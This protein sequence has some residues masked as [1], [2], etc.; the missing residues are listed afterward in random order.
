MNYDTIVRPIVECADAL[1]ATPAQVALAWVLAQSDCIVV[2][3][4]TQRYSYLQENWQAGD[5]V[6]P[7]Q[8]MERLNVL[9]AP[10]GERY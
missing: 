3:P 7:A 2:I 6:L 4:G 1:D 5:L 10:V 8:W 9:P